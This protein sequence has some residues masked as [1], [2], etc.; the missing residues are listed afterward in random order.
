MP[1][2]RATGEII[3]QW[4]CMFALACSEGCFCWALHLA[5]RSPRQGAPLLSDDLP[6][7]HHCMTGRLWRN[8]SSCSSVKHRAA[9]GSPGLQATALGRSD[10]AGKLQSS[11]GAS[12]AAGRPAVAVPPAAADRGGKLLHALLADSGAG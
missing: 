1:L 12:V 11:R 5:P 4:E 6:C 2:A 7:S 10:R 3:C 8:T 9:L